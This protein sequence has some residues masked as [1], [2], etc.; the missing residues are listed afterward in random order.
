MS[1]SSQGDA[2]RRRAVGFYDSRTLGLRRRTLV[3]TIVT[4]VCA[5]FVGSAQ[6]ATWPQ[7]LFLHRIGW[8]IVATFAGV[9][10]AGA[11][12]SNLL[13]RRAYAKY[14]AERRRL[15]E[16]TAQEQAAQRPVQLPAPVPAPAVAV[17]AVPA[18]AVVAPAP[19]L[20]PAPAP[21]PVFVAQ[22]AAAPADIDVR[23]AEL[24]PAET[25]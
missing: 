15:A 11:G 22:H 19:Q 7:V 12:A 6:A 4:F 5:A 3:T 8:A 13:E 16:K 23:H 20:A 9:A 2:V 14:T 1:K 18:P 25:R 17:P 10:L 21:V 24:A